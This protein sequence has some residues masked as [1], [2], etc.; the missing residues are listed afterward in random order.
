MSNKDTGR[1]AATAWPCVIVQADFQENT[2]TVEMKTANFRVAAGTYWLCSAP[3]AEQPANPLTKDA[4]RAAGGIVCSDG[5]VFFTSIEQLNKAV[6]IK[7]TT[8]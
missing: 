1:P 3:P 6:G 5:N 7:E 8:P 4:I 2:L